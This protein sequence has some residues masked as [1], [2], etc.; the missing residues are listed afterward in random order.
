MN[1]AELRASIARAG[2]TNRKL[3]EALGLS[4]QSFYNKIQGI[5]EFK[6]SEIKCLANTLHLSMNELNTIFFD[7][8]VN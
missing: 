4:E 6:G 8:K 1:C 7:R 3:A 2:V 5:T